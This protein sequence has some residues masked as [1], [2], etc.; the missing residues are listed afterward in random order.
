MK[1]Y[2]LLALLSVITLTLAA[3]EKEQKSKREIRAEN[4]AKIAAKVDSLI[5]AK[6]FRFIA[7]SANPMG[8]SSISLT[9]EYDLLINGDS[10]KVDLP[11]YGR[12]YRADYMATEGGIKLKNTVAEDFVIDQ[13]KKQYQVNFKARSNDDLYQFRLS[14]SSS[15]YGTLS[16]TCNNRQSISF[17]GILDGLG[18]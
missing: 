10:V 3:Q 18:L 13:K 11:Y 17:N 16:V 5:E 6:N 12:A 7:R 8:W 15:G 4:N 2:L 1:R 14:V 9:S